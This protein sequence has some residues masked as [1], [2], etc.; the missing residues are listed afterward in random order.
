MAT[1]YLGCFIFGVLFVVVTVVFGDIVGGIFDGIFDFLSFELAFIQPLTIVGG[2]A[3]FGGSG[4][5]LDQFSSLSSSIIFL[6]SLCIAVIASVMSYI[7][8]IK[9][10]SKAENSLAFSIQDLV[11]QLGEVSIPVPNDGFGQVEIKSKTG[12][13]YE[14]A[15]SF[16]QKEIA[17]GQKVVVVEEREGALY[18]SPLKEDEL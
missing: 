11:G 5:L 12:N 18:V 3:A 13:V 10:M 14:I 6:L 17:L 8:Y 9:P 2:L 16:D 1:L 4:L 15:A 7:L